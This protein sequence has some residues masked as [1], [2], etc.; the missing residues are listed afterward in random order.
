MNKR[1]DTGGRWGI[2]AV[3]FF[4]LAAFPA[5]PQAARPAWTVKP[6]SDTDTTLFFRGEGRGKT[7]QDA[8][9]NAAA[10]ADRQI[11]AFMYQFIKHEYREKL[12]FLSSMG[13]TIQ[14]TESS[15]SDTG[16][17]TELVV[18]GIKTVEEYLE[19]RAGAYQAWV[20]RTISPMEVKT[21]KEEFAKK[22]SENYNNLITRQNTLFGAFRSYAAVYAM[23]EKNPLHR[24]IAFH[25]GPEGRALL[26]Y[27]CAA[28]M[29]SLAS[30]V[31]FTVPDAAA[32]KGETLPVTVDLVSRRPDLPNIGNAE[33]RISI[34]GKDGSL[35]IFAGTVKNDNTL[36]FSVS[37]SSLAIGRH[38]AK[39]ELLLNESGDIDSLVRKNP[40]CSFSF[41]VTPIPADIVFDG[42]ELSAA[43]QRIL[44]NGL[45]QGLEKAGAGIQAEIASARKNA[46][47][48]GYR[49]IISVISFTGEEEAPPPFKGTYIRGDFSVDFARDG[50]TLKLEE[51]AFNASSRD[52]V[53]R[54]AANWIRDN[55]GFYEGI[56]EKLTR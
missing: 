9:N 16:M 32:Q 37:T 47:P 55:R 8:R 46:V 22:I 25:D 19:S 11:A 10:D 1:H 12:S 3:L 53:V 15:E 39:I 2:L 41:E 7:E 6:P 17:Y 30:G 51:A 24:M 27:Y 38:E 40:G 56:I 34:S 52:W 23:L 28:Q 44:A 43:E 18:S 42:E 29:N 48:G 5:L 31:D 33:G 21:Q 54:G 4:L 50:L 35:S 36:S 20:L 13:E 14:D 26:Y 45:R 49:F